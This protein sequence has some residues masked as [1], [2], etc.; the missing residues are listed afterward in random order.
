MLGDPVPHPAGA[1]QP[2]E[3]RR[4]V[5]RIGLR[6]PQRAESTSTRRTRRRLRFSIVDTRRRDHA[7]RSR[8]GC[9]SASARPTRRC[10]ANSAAPGL[11][12]RDLQSASSS[13]MGGEIGVFSEEGRG[14]N[15]WFTLT[16]P[17]VRLEFA[18]PPVPD[19]RGDEGHR[20]PAAGRG[21]RHQPVA[22]AHAARDR[23]PHGRY[24]GE[25]RGGDRGGPGRSATISC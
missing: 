19:R 20:P 7:S 23:R 17:R 25:R 15:F 14:A 8:T 4:Q 22:G 16:L 2:A 5:H 6:R 24:R 18:A 12:P 10:R 3:Q 1:A 13:L 21:H 11:G 9:S